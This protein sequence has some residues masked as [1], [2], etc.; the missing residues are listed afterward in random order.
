MYDNQT[1]PDIPSHYEWVSTPQNFYSEKEW[2]TSASIQIV[3]AS[4]SMIASTAM[5]ISIISHHKEVLK[6]SPY[7]RLILSLAFSDMIYSFSFI[8][9]PFDVPKSYKA[10]GLWAT[11]NDTTCAIT[12]AIHT[13]GLILSLLNYATICFYHVMKLKA[14]FSDSRFAQ[15]FEKILFGC[16]YFLPIGVVASSFPMHIVGADPEGLTCTCGALEKT[17]CVEEGEDLIC[18]HDSRSKSN[19]IFSWIFVNELGAFVLLS[20]VISMGTLAW[21]VMRQNRIY[22]SLSIAQQNNDDSPNRNKNQRQ[23]IAES[24]RIIFFRQSLMQG[25]VSS[26]FYVL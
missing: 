10:M 7:F 11:G 20:V 17:I 3:S 12:A 13:F 21:H 4:V 26:Y 18:A 8:L 16:M 25:F 6:K 22:R 24:L 19:L 15:K 9:G 23:I 5:L 2:I 1:L 14:R